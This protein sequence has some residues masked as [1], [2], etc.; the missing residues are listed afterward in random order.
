MRR[1]QVR[2]CTHKEEINE[3]INKHARE[4]ANN[5]SDNNDDDDDD[6]GDDGNGATMSQPA[7]FGG[8]DKVWH[9][10]EGIGTAGAIVEIAL[11]DVRPM[12]SLGLFGSVNMMRVVRCRYVRYTFGEWIVWFMLLPG[13]KVVGVWLTFFTIQCQLLN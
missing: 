11:C 2:A 8:R 12:S 13:V 5:N 4:S 3:H 10:V 7:S 1:S 9:G 6:D